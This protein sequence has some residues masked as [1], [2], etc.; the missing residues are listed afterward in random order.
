LT[1]TIIGISQKKIFLFNIIIIFQMY[2]GF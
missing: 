1:T 2:L